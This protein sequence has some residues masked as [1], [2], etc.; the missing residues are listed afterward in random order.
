MNA[1]LHMVT[2]SLQAGKDSE[3]AEAFLS[4]SRKILTEIPGVENFKVLR[5][6]SSKNEHDYGFSMSFSDRTSYEAYNNHPVHMKY[7]AEI[8]ESK[9]SSFQEIDLVAYE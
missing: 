1:I 2:F 8:W 4:E 6:V 5:Q 3:E 7:V 9:V